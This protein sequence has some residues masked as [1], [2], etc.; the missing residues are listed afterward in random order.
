MAA[1]L[2]QIHIVSQLL[3]DNGVASI[4][5][6]RWQGFLHPGRVVLYLLAYKDVALLPAFFLA[7]EGA[8]L[9]QRVAGF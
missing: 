2:V 5:G 6:I 9:H 1:H 7:Q 4:F 8:V 3:I